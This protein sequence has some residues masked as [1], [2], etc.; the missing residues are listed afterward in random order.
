MRFALEGAR[1][2]DLEATVRYEIGFSPMDVP[3]VLS[4]TRLDFAFI[5]G[6]HFGDAPCADV[7]AVLPHLDTGRCVLI[8]H[9]AH[10]EAVAKAVFYAAE[11]IGGDINSLNTR[12]RLIV[13]SRGFDPALIRECRSIISRQYH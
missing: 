8:F 2:L 1:R 6:S 10:S 9:D 13:V 12:N 4:G 11:K 5:D 3:A 7:D